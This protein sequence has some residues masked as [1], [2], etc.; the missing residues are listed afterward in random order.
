MNKVYE[1]NS[2]SILINGDTIKEM[3]KL[4]NNG[5]TVD[6]V[7]TSPPYNTQ[8][9]LDDRAYDVYQDGICNNVYL[10][11]TKSIFDCYDELLSEDGVIL[12]NLSYG[13]ENPTVMFDVISKITKDT[14]FM[15]ADVIAWK[16]KT[17]IPNCMSHNKLTRI[18]EYI[19]VICRKSEYKT[20]KTNRQVSSYRSTGQK[21]YHATYNFI[22]ANNND[23]SCKLNKATYSTQLCD[24]LMDEYLRPNA[25]VM[26][27]FA[28]TG[29]TLVSALKRNNRFIGIEL[30]E[31]QC[32]WSNE[33]LIKEL[34]KNETLR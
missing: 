32:E 19:Y 10:D 21:N 15:V 1:Y 6:M 31:D 26:D 17:A 25:I 29:T 4:I 9:N 13:N 5:V 30:S 33:R 23:G 7:L 22:E 18:V 14:P 27:N 24:I 34:N 11:W 3:N 28:G 16:K 2:G 20:F 8:R 12:Y